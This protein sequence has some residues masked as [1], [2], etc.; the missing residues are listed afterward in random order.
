MVGEALTTV[1]APYAVWIDVSRS[2]EGAGALSEIGSLE[3][4]IRFAREELSPQH[5]YIEVTDYLG[6][7]VHEEHFKEDA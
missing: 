2:E 1:G 3:E 4:A 6:N 5:R 7:T